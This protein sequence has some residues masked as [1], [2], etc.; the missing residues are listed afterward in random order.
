MALLNL[1]VASILRIVRQG[2]PDQ[3]VLLEEMTLIG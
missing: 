3:I 2:E 1:V